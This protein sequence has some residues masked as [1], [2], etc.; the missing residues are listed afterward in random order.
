MKGSLRVQLFKKVKFMYSSF[1]QEFLSKEV[2]PSRQ[3]KMGVFQLENATTN[4]ISHG[5]MGDWITLT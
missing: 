3:D 1:N 4:S 2:K 5:R